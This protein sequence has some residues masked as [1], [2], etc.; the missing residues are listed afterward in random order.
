MAT[1]K[2]Y[3]NTSDEAIKLK[4]YGQLEIPAGE[5]ISVST[6]YHQPVILANYPGLRDITDE[7]VV[8]KKKGR[9][10]VKEAEASDE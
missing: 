1:T 2:V 7:E 8:V 3:L 10:A 9:A 4:E 6:E 5:Q